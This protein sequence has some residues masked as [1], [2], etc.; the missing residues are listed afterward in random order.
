MSKDCRNDCVEPIIF[1]GKIKNRPGLSHIDYRIGGYSDFRE[2]LMHNL[3]KN[4]VLSNWTH[5]NADDP[6][7]AL[8]EGVSILGDI[9]TFYQELYANEAYLRTAQWRESIADL[10]Q[11]LGY[12]L[13]PGFGGRGTFAFE[14]RGDKPVVIPAGFPIKAEVTGSEQP[15]DFVTVNEFEAIPALSKFHLYRPFEHP[16]IKKGT[17]KFLIEKSDLNENGLELSEGDKLM[18]VEDPGD[19][20]TYKQIVVVSETHERFERTEI[21][22]AGNWQKESPVNE[23]NAY[24]IGRT[25]RHFGYNAPQKETVVMENNISQNDVNFSKD[26][27]DKY[28]VEKFLKRDPGG[29]INLIEKEILVLVQHLLDQE[30]NDISVG[31]I[32]LIN[33][34]LSKDEPGRGQKYFFEKTVTHVTSASKTFGAITGGTTVFTFQDNVNFDDFV[35][36][37]I[38]TIEYHEVLGKVF[39]LKSVLKA[40]D[41]SERNKLVFYGNYVSYTLLRNRRLLMVKEDI[42]E[43]SQVTEII[44]EAKPPETPRLRELVIN[45][46]LDSPGCRLSYDDFPFE[47]PIV[48]VYGNLVEATQGKTEKEA[49]LGNGDNR[50]KF[51]TFKLPKAPLTYHHSAEET[52]PE[53]PELHI[54]V[55]DRLWKRV[56]TFF[57]RK[58]KEEIYIVREDANGDSWV[59][60]GDGKTGTRLPSGIKNVIAKYRTGAGAFGALKE[61]TTVQA[62]GKLDR[63][64]NIHLPGVVSGGS[65]PESGDTAREAAPGK[66]QS[67]DRLVGIKDFE[68]EA[69]AI[70]GVSKVTASWDLINNIP[71]V[72]LTVLMETERDQEIKEVQQTLNNY[73]KCRGPQRFP[74]KVCPGKLRY[75]YIDATFGLHP[76]FREEQVKKEIKKALGVA[77]EKGNGIDGSRGLFGIKQRRF[78]QA[79]YATRIEGSIQNVEGVVW[80]E[81]KAF[82]LLED[83]EGHPSELSLPTEP[84]ELSPVVTCN[85]LQILSLYKD[86]I[87]LNV[88]TG[89]TME[90]C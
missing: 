19:P 42:T 51:Q 4:P 88:A 11:L 41:P 76:A 60:F 87:Q 35:Y 16:L 15:A 9:L 43:D 81:V 67:L 48:T 34:E 74:V 49:I 57:D 29:R 14:V 56:S 61:E 71:T 22:I 2:A 20:T 66:I 86:H 62:G 18:L 31:S 72:V 37:D 38:R 17:K 3:N 82:G 1:P 21:T 58:P 27:S 70:S 8:L 44:E 50:E 13:A 73:N 40:S 63:L 10:V 83:R 25:F 46:A 59:Q 12:R 45:K 32:M 68:T 23:L 53:T 36:T 80:A 65:K 33:L 6:G 69:L 52:P 5:R 78:G 28:L 84:K 77:G 7:I 39:K 47:A 30:V 64:D 54:Y 79:E 90:E 55:N 26:L 85:N 89:K 24:K 75:T